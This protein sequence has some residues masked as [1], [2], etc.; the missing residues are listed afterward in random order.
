MQKRSFI[1]SSPR[2]LPCPT[3][4]RILFPP[5][6]HLHSSN[7][8]NVPP[9]DS[10][11]P[12]DPDIDPCRPLLAFLASALPENHLELTSV[13]DNVDEH[14]SKMGMT[15]KTHLLGDHSTLVMSLT[16]VPGARQVKLE[17][18]W[19]KKTVTASLPQRIVGVVDRESDSPMPFPVAIEEG[20]VS[21][22]IISVSCLY[23]RKRDYLP[24]PEF[25]DDV[26]DNTG[27]QQSKE[28][29][30]KIN[31]VNHGAKTSN[32]PV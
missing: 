17:H 21:L 6:N 4:L 7:C 8:A 3:F 31:D 16:D 11:R 15:P 32:S 26:Y 25:T 24:Q 2:K 23:Q 19:Y 12:V 1:T 14:A 13:L 28:K 29:A 27:V 9:F 22:E 10:S 5:W 30:D 20:I 18:N